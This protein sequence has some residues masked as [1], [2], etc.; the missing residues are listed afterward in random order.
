MGN[1]E[2]R[3][4]NFRPSRTHQT[5]KSQNLPFPKSKGNILKHALLAQI[6]HPQ[7]LVRCF[8]ML[9]WVNLRQLT[10]HH[11]HYQLILINLIRIVCPDILPVPEH[12]NLIR[13]LKYLVHLMG[14][15]YDAPPVF[16]KTVDDVKQIGNLTLRDCRRR[17]IH[18]DDFRI[19]RQRLCNLNHL[20]LRDSQLFH[21]HRRREV[22]AYPLHQGCRFTVHF[23]VIDKFPLTEFLSEKKILRNGHIQDRA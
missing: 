7:Y 22:N 20:H 16:L 9:W 21:Q 13:N 23:P 19:I 15:V 8:I 14:N 6:F 1:S 17:L 5:G 11:L 18:N 4:H 12:S 3:V 2:Q 10:V